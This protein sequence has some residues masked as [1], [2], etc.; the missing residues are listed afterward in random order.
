MKRARW[1]TNRAARRVRVGVSAGAVM[2]L[3]APASAV[4]QTSILANVE[5]CNRVDRASPSA[6][7][8]GCTAVIKSENPTSRMLAVAHNNRGNAYAGRGDY[9][10]AIGDYDEALKFVPNYPKALNNRGVAYQK[11]GEYDRAI[12]DFDL[13]IELEGDYARAFANRAD[14]YL[15]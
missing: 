8:D 7:I 3:F 14:T 10:G 4:A 9:D 11:K 6:Q 12:K 2:L 15:Y 1:Y 5:L 13:A